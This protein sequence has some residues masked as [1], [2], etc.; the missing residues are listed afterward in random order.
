MPARGPQHKPDLFRRYPGVRRV[1]LCLTAALVLACASCGNKNNIYPVSGKVTY[2]GSPASGAT[3][4]FCPKGGATMNDHMIMGV[5]QGDGSFELA[6]GSLGKGAPPGEY[7]VLIEWKQV[8]G[9]GKGRPRHGP[10][11][12]KGRYA[13]PEHPLLHATVEAKTNDLPPVELTN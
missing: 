4:F 3:V 13:D 12:L 5:V 7:D 9:Q 2:K 6:C 10:D 11:K 1:V 8:S